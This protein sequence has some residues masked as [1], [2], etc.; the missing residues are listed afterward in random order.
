MSEEFFQPIEHIIQEDP[1]GCMI[2][3]LAMIRGVSYQEVKAEFYG[4]FENDGITEGVAWDYLSAYGYT[5]IYRRVHCSSN[6][7]EGHLHLKQP[8]APVHL[9]CVRDFANAP[10]YHGVVMLDDGKILNPRK[11]GV[12][13][14]SAYFEVISVAGVWKP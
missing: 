2:A 12:T 13:E 8:F 5:V 9:V 10:H 6:P 1:A 4:G 3:C 7:A 11:N 14:L